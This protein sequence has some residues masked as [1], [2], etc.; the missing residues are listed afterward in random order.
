MIR[1]G[2]LGS[3]RGSNLHSI[4]KAISHQYLQASIEV[5][6]SNKITAPILKRAQ[7]FGIK[8]V[9]ANPADKSRE[10]FDAYLSSLLKQHKVELVVLLGY[11]RILGNQF[12]SHWENQII[13]VH[14]SL[15]PAFAGLMDLEVHRAVLQSNASITGCSVHLVTKDVDAGPLLVQKTCPILPGDTPEHLKERVQ[16]LEGSAL[17]EAILKCAKSEFCY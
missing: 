7:E 4:V 15:L 17:V 10:A 8:S 5:V 13:N 1:L 6:I 11:M 12:V 3:T 9:F 16:A 14:P 2:I